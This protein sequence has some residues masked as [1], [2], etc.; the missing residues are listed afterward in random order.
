MARDGVL[1]LPLELRSLLAVGATEQVADNQQWIVGL[2]RAHGQQVVCMLWRMLGREADV[3][4]A[5]QGTMCRLL[6]AGQA[7]LGRNPGGYF[8]RAAMNAAIELIRTRQRRRR[9]W[10]EL[11]DHQVRR[12]A[13]R[14]LS[15]LDQS[16]TLQRMREAVFQLPPH[17][18]D[19]IVLRELASLPYRQV[20]AVLG[21]RAGTARLY[22]RQAMLRL[23]DLLGQEEAS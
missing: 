23:A 6:A 17:L 13:E 9:Q 8:Y 4:D 5:Y 3:L 19:T 7:A 20:A 14:E 15:H 16:D 11:I 1:A 22:R 10:P 12:D 21:I 2:M 18:R